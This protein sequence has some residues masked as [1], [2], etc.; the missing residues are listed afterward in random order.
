MS[1][2]TPVGRAF[3]DLPE[4]L[5]ESWVHGV[6]IGGMASAPEEFELARSYAEAGRQLVDPALMSGEAWRLAYP[7]FFLYR[8]ALELYL[9][10]AVQ[11]PRPRHDLLPLISEFE[12]LLREHIHRRIP[13]HLKEDLM[14]FAAIDPDAQGF[15]YSHLTS[16]K[17]RLLPGEYW[18]PLRDLR[19][20]M[21]E[22][23]AF[24]E[25]AIHQL[26]S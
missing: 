16:G 8:H 20:F 19:R 12:D 15:R 22:L 14:V 24:I 6:L 2:K 13:S 7:I 26:P 18:V 23:F 3:Q 5:D 17:P 25:D 10:A 21:D 1:M 4:G 11:P 9:K